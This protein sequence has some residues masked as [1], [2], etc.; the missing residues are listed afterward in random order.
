M[1]IIRYLWFFFSVG[2]IVNVF[3]EKFVL[4]VRISVG[5]FDVSNLLVIVCLFLVY[6]LFLGNMVFRLC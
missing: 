3:V 2:L 6:F 4:R 1:V 5:M